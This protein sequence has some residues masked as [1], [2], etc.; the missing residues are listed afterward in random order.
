MERG[1]PTRFEKS[2]LKQRQISLE[3]YSAITASLARLQALPEV[4]SE[5][6]S[7]VELQEELVIAKRALMHSD[8]ENSTAHAA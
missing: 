4:S 8:T 6:S 2:D 5:H 7:V 3:I 1:A